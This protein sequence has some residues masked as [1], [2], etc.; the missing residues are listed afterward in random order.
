MLIDNVYLDVS[1]LDGCLPA[2]NQNDKAQSTW[3]AGVLWRKL[4]PKL[5]RS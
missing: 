1:G 2:P 4:P 3:H 5:P